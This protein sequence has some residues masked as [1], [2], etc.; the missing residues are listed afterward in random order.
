M[1]SKMIKIS[2]LEDNFFSSQTIPKAM[3][4]SEHKVVI[5]R[6]LFQ[7]VFGLRV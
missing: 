3:R 4:G 5:R 7:D 1:Q 2:D 6:I